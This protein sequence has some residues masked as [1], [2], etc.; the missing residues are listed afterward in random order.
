MKRMLVLLG[1]LCVAPYCMAD[2]ILYEHDDFQ[3]RSM[4][5]TGSV[6][7]FSNS[8]FNDITSSV[9]VRSGSWLVCEHANFQ[10]RCVTL[11][12][13]RY[14]SLNRL[15]M[16]DVISSVREVGG[17]DRRDYAPTPPQR[18]ERPDRYRGASAQLFEGTN[19]TGRDLVVEDSVRDLG[20]TG[21]NQRAGSL[22]ISSGSFQVCSEADF[23]GRCQTLGPGDYPGFNAG[24]ASAR[25]VTR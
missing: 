9:V 13:G 21:F 17:G 3:G 4:R 8:D 25:P 22:R 14:R 6:R 11:Q 7:D 20:D 16:N 18:G 12:P 2:L 1:L 24:I 19:F 23:R 10:G 5:V 15:G